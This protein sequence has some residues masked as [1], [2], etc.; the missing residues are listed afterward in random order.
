METLLFISGGEIFVI[1]L[2]A[3]IFFGSDRIPE[4]AKGLGKGVREFKKA[5]EDIKKEFA[6]SELSRDVEAIKKDLSGALEENVARPVENMQQDFT[7]TFQKHLVEPMDGAVSDLSTT[8][9]SSV[10]EYSSYDGYDESY[11][12]Q[13]DV[14][15]V[16]AASATTAA[17]TVASENS[18][19]T[20]VSAEQANATPSSDSGISGTS[21]V[22]VDFPSEDFYFQQ[23]VSATSAKDF[24]SP[25]PAEGTDS[26]APALP[27]ETE[28]VHQA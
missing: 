25:V 26:P 27:S 17:T 10:P 24:S 7:R 4:L 18:A 19:V 2:F 8:T 3:L 20:N 9:S 21:S 23:Q 11:F 5:A 22:S 16:E 1:F 6:N 12:P 13:P 14:T 15:P 28:P